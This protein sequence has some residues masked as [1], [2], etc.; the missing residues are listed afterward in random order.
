MGLQMPLEVFF[1]F[2]LQIAMGTI[3]IA[4]ISILAPFTPPQLGVQPPRASSSPRLLHMI[5]ADVSSE[6]ISHTKID[7]ADFACEEDVLRVRGVGLD[8]VK[9]LLLANVPS[10][11]HQA[12]QLMLGVALVDVVT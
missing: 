11:T 3:K 5:P 6:V 8:V 10:P 12:G 9:E 1:I 4:V 2:V 7:P